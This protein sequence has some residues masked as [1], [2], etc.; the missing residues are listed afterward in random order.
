MDIGS[1][2]RLAH[3]V[4]SHLRA[5]VIEATCRADQCVSRE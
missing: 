4:V 1:M 2:L 3:N 5:I